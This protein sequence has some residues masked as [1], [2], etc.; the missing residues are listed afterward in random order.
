M[1]ATPTL[2]FADTFTEMSP[3]ETVIS[4]VAFDD[5]DVVKN[6]AEA[7]NRRNIW[8]TI[9]APSGPAPSVD[10]TVS[11]PDVKTCH[12]PRQLGLNEAEPVTLQTNGV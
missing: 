10:T 9:S 7:W 8:G 3:A 1:A 2:E 5:V 6:S 12:P 11:P 4:K